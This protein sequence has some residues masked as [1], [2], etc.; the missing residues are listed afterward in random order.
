MILI[1]AGS[2]NI[3]DIKVLYSAL[4]DT[5]IDPDEIDEVVSGTARGVDRLGEYWATD[6]EI[7]VIKFPANWDKFGKSAGYI[8]NAKMAEYSDTLLA[9]WDGKSKGTK[10]M[11]DLM[12]KQSKAVVIYI[13][14]ENNT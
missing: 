4:H 12:K 9:I 5:G 13:P 3:T 10:H 11:I 7:N 6:N 8:R 2:R 1:I 14:K